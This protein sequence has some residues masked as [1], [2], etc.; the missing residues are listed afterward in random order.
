MAALQRVCMRP[1][2]A[3]VASAPIFSSARRAFPIFAT[4][5]VSGYGFEAGEM[6][7]NW[8]SEGG[9]FGGL[10]VI[11][12]FEPGAYIVNGRWTSWD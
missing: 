7:K 3:L 2:S 1:A 8:V 10:Y 6:A 4:V 12:V 11:S 9:E 5:L